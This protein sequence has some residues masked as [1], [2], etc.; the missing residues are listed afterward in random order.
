MKAASNLR[1]VAWS[2]SWFSDPLLM[3]RPVCNCLGIDIC[4]NMI[5][6]IHNQGM[7]AQKNFPPVQDRHKLIYRLLD[8]ENSFPI[9]AEFYCRLL[10]CRRK[11]PLFESDHR[12]RWRAAPW[13]TGPHSNGA[14]AHHD[15]SFR[16]S[17]PAL[18]SALFSL[19]LRLEKRSRFQQQEDNQ[20]TD[21]GP[22]PYSQNFYQVINLC[23]DHQDELQFHLQEDVFIWML[24]AAH[25]PEG[26]GRK[27][28]SHLCGG[29]LCRLAQTGC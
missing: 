3:K 27:K 26:C 28:S 29:A 9:E 25:S 16:Q 19:F 4:H 7:G 12:K 24:S 17:P 21:S 5:H 14:M 1:R 10:P 20:M 8:S 18:G 6:F 23:F 22:F 13:A 2:S 11:P 15:A